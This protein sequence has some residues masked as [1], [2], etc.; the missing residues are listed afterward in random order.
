MAKA[1]LLAAPTAADSVE[2]DPTY[3]RGY[4]RS[5]EQ[6]GVRKVELTIEDAD[7][8][9]L[10]TL[11]TS[12]ISGMFGANRQHL[13]PNA[14]DE[15]K[16]TAPEKPDLESMARVL[17]DTRGEDPY[18]HTGITFYYNVNQAS[19]DPRPSRAADDD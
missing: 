1:P 6:K 19:S 4:L 14:Y 5:A 17:F 16:S 9:T 2:S 7:Q 11:T 3:R 12:H 13:D 10:T 15:V 8:G 18:G